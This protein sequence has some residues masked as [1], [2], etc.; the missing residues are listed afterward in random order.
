VHKGV[1]SSYVVG[2]RKKG[3]KKTSDTA[4]SATYNERLTAHLTFNAQNATIEIS[5]ARTVAGIFIEAEKRQ[6]NRSIVGTKIQKSAMSVHCCPSRLKFRFPL[7]RYVKSRTR[8]H[9]TRGYTRE[10]T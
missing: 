2:N 4:H 1:E 10:Y 7:P 8:Q 9:A 3:K 6:R 5:L